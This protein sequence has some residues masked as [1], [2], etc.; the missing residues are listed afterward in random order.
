VTQY[1]QVATK[2]QRLRA[3]AAEAAEVRDALTHPDVVALRV[4]KL[5]TVVDRF[6][7][8]GM[9]LGLLFTMTNVQQFTADTIDAQ[10]GDLE[11]WAAW[12]LDP[13]VSVILLGVLLAERE[14][15]RWSLPDRW[16]SWS[17]V[18]KWSLLSATYVMNTW[19]SYADGNLAGI[20]LHS[21]PPLAVFVGAEA[22]S[23]CQ[24]KLTECVHRAHGAA[25]KRATERAEARRRL[26]EAAE[27]AKD[28]ERTDR[29]AD[30]E[31]DARIAVLRSETSA[32]I[33]ENVASA[34][35]TRTG[36]VVFGGTSPDRSE[37]T[38]QTGP[39]VG[40]RPV[41]DEV[42][43]RS[44]GRSETDAQAGPKPV[45]DAG[46]DRS[47]TRSQTGP[48]RRPGTSRTAGSGRSGPKS[49]PRQRTDADL[50]RDVQKLADQNDG[51]PPTKYE[52]KQKLGVGHER[53]ARLLEQLEP[54][55]VGAP[56]TNGAA[57][58]SE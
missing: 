24:E 27:A 21:V 33:A 7:W 25:I 55:P 19:Q 44:G 52:L 5:R 41:P 39:R 14:T 56:A 45:R 54:E 6:I 2:A 32:Q 28:T 8:T 18:A 31:T 3:E 42:S 49:G 11:W 58:T 13:T 40:L 4:E 50:L 30:A 17:Q 38:T 9:V 37:A 51:E 16:R 15:S 10:R 20:V 12:L 43:D 34:T 1:R 35:A 46:S 57:K 36:P 53:A 48:G 22:V 29:I 47:G 23:D 26:A